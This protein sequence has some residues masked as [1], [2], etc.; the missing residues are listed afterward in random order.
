MSRVGGRGQSGASKA[1]LAVTSLLL[2]AIAFEAVLRLVL[3]EEEVNGNYWGVG[4]FEA[5]PGAGYRHAEGFEGFAYRRGVFDVPVRIAE[6]GL[7]QPDL[8]GQLG[9]PERILVLGD[10][11]AF[12]LGVGEAEALPRRLA[13][14]FNP[15]RVGVINGA[16]TGYSAIQEAEFGAWLS[17]RVRPTLILQF[18]FLANDV[19]DDYQRSH[20]RVEVHYG[21][22]LPR[23]RRLRGPFFDYL[24]THSYSWMFVDG[25]IG[26]QR[27]GEARRSLRRRAREQPGGFV[28]PTIDA[29]LMLHRHCARQGIRF[30]VALVPYRGEATV[31]ADP[32]TSALTRCGVPLLDLAPGGF[33]PGDHLVGDSHWSPDGHRRAAA[34]VAPFLDEL[35]TRQAPS[36][37]AGAR[38]PDACGVDPRP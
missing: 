27:T 32:V 6:H 26:R 11:F 22:R 31:Y 7:R 10:S 15:R 30:G 34:L 37:N 36:L 24:R 20:E 33:E 25:R 14:R 21:Y 16:Q 23:D 8:A 38:L 19:L 4:A 17:E 2:T 1:L 3:R 35:L 12:G 9:Y 5:F 13:E 29:V 28:G 18:L